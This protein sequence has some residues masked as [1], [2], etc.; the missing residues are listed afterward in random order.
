MIVQ[1]TRGSVNG[2]AS[3]RQAGRNLVAAL[4]FLHE[5]WIPG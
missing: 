4:F 5:V 3:P 2:L 1:V